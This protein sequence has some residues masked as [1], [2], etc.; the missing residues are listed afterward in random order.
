MVCNKNIIFSLSMYLIKRRVI[1]EYG[2]MEVQLHQTQ[3]S[4]RSRPLYPQEICPC[5][6][7]QQPV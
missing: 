2:G 1:K 4:F 7:L 6:H 5:T 3:A